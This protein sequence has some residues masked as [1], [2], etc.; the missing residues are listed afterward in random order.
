M[1]TTEASSDLEV[2]SEKRNITKKVNFSEM[3]YFSEKLNNLHGLLINK[4]YNE[5]DRELNNLIDDYLG[6][7]YIG[8]VISRISSFSK[9][10]PSDR[11]TILSK[12][13]DAAI[14]L[15]N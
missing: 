13:Y 9:E 12:L 11:E 10:D 3:K 14:G 8:S 2:E 1:Q 15:A 5:F 6:N 7:L 4:E